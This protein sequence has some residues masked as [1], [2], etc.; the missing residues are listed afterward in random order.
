MVIL[1]L[2]LLLMRTQEASTN[3][4][5]LEDDLPRAVKEM[6]NFLYS[7]D[8][9]SHNWE[10][11]TQKMDSSLDVHFQMYIISDKYDIPALR[12]LA[13]KNLELAIYDIPHHSQTEKIQQPIQPLGFGLGNLIEV[14]RAVYNKPGGYQSDENLRKSIVR[15]SSRYMISLREMS[16]FRDLLMQYKDFA[17]DLALY[18][19]ST[20]AKKHSC[21]NGRYSYG[22]TGYRHIMKCQDCHAGITV[23][24]GEYGWIGWEHPPRPRRFPSVSIEDY[25]AIT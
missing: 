17:A 24:P 22:S 2:L 19:I 20:Y 9:D 12:D 18:G 5:N 14:L 7:A 16:E 1:P 15:G 23:E 10:N 3:V 21:P 11:G 13:A 6:I 25:H 8:Y 4:I